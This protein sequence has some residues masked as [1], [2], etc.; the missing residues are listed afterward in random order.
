LVVTNN[1]GQGV[2]RRSGQIGLLAGQH[3]IVVD[4]SN[5]GGGFGLEVLWDP[6]GGNTLVNIPNANLAVSIPVI[7]WTG[8]GADGK[9]STAA[10]WTPRV[11][12]SG[13]AVILTCA[14]AQRPT[15]MDIANLTLFSLT[16]DATSTA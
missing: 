3:S 16:F 15:S 9:W 2:T 11:P 8:G 12:V 5:T 10:N 14:G 7:T 4:Y 1:A 13:D 6:A